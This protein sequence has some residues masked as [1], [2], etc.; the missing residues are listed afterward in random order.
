MNKFSLDSRELEFAFPCSL[1][2]SK[3]KPVDYC[4]E[5]IGYGIT[6]MESY[7]MKKK[8]EDVVNE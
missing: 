5:C 1:C 2:K 4:K 7:D 3:Y 6:N 8:I